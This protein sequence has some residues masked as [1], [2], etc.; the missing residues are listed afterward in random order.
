MSNQHCSN[1]QHNLALKS[2]KSSED[3]SNRSSVLT[4]KQM[5]LNMQSNAAIEE[6]DEFSPED[7]GSI[8]RFPEEEIKN[9]NENMSEG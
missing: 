2:L 4:H 6:K 8:I 7:S 9:N 1:E 5:K 3:V